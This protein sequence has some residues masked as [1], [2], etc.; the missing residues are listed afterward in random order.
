LQQYRHPQK[1]DPHTKLTNKIN[2]PNPLKA[3]VPI[4]KDTIESVVPFVVP[5]VATFVDSDA[6]NAAALNPGPYTRGMY[7]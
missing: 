6:V 7:L 4:S 5:F 2:N 1:H 3:A